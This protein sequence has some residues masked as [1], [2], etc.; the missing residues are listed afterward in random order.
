MLKAKNKRLKL[1]AIR[2]PHS[3]A[4]S[5]PSPEKLHEKYA[6]YVKTGVLDKV[7][8]DE[9]MNLVD[10]YISV[11]IARML[12][13]KN[14]QRGAVLVDPDKVNQKTPPERKDGFTVEKYERLLRKFQGLDASQDPY[15]ICGRE[16]P[17]L[18][19]IFC[20]DTDLSCADFRRN[21]PLEAY[22]RL[23]DYY[24]GDEK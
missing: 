7:Y 3:F 17:C 11:L 2:I 15:S 1:E 18:G 21:Y 13:V 9:D 24:A 5:R 16:A 23:V 12:G 4:G 20:T 22:A 6:R 14:I 8:V 10:G 19:C